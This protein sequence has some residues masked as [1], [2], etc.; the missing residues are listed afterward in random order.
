MVAMYALQ[1]KEKQFLDRGLSQKS[2]HLLGEFLGKKTRNRLALICLKAIDANKESYLDSKVAKIGRPIS[3]EAILAGVL[4]VSV[5]TVNRWMDE[6]GI[7]ASD[8]NA[9]RLAELAYNYFPKDVII[10]RSEAEDHLSL[11]E[12]WLSIM[13][14]KL[15][16]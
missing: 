2:P 11:V 7:Q 15:E 5:R 13:S 4:E 10:L 16:G 9:E 14:N 1:D 6:Q 12:S 3:S 8:L